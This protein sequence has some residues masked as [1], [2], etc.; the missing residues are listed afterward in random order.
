MQILKDKVLTG[1]RDLLQNIAKSY[2]DVILRSETYLQIL[3][4]KV[5]TG[6][7][8][9]LQNIAKSYLDVILRSETFGDTER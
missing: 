1:V 5:L 9:L 3:K 2:L 8:D 4:D 7:R 6:V